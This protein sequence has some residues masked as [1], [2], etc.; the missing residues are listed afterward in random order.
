MSDS[1]A[2]E[3]GYR[4]KWT[5][6]LPK[7]DSIHPHRNL[8]V[9]MQEGPGSWRAVLV[10]LEEFRGSGSTECLAIDDLADDLEHVAA[11]IRRAS[12]LEALIALRHA[13][14]NKSSSALHKPRR[15]TKA[16][17]GKKAA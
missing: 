15:K 3:D 8:C 16:K 2:R 13:G 17:K 10:D 7:L 4:H 11:E 1:A 9:Q 12:S 5:L 14:R 6:E